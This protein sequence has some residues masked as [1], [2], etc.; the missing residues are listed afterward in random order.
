VQ[1]TALTIK[2]GG[3][4]LARLGRHG[5]IIRS[6]QTRTSGTK[7][8]ANTLTRKPQGCPIFPE[9]SGTPSHAHNVLEF[10]AVIATIAGRTRSA[11]GKDRVLAVR[12]HARLE[13]ARSAQELYRDLIALSGTGEEPPPAAPP[14]VRA[15]LEQLETEGAV[16]SGEDLWEFRRLLDE[17]AL[18]HAWTRKNRNETPGLSR[19]LA[20]IEPLPACAGATRPANDNGERAGQDFARR[21]YTQFPAGSE[22]WLAQDFEWPEPAQGQAEINF[23]ADKVLLVEAPDFFEIASRGYEALP[24]DEPLVD[25]LAD[26]QANILYFSAEMAI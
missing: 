15:L 23:F 18:A 16:L 14:D 13:D 25:Y 26:Q 20:E 10:P 19:L 17:A 4:P 12:C 1:V 9:A 3:F 8:I 21:V 6:N 7:V 22:H 11:P 24:A 5:I 2:P